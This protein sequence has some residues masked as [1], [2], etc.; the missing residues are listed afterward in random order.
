MCLAIPSKIIEIKEGWAT[1]ES[2]DHIHCAN[3]SLVPEAEIGDYVLAHG[4][5]ALNKVEKEE[6]EK[7][8]KMINNREIN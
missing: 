1:L 5:M 2:G 6:A 3:L 8:L 4:D 7:I